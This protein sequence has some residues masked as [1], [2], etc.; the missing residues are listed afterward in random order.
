MSYRRV[1][2]LGDLRSPVYEVPGNPEPSV[3]IALMPERR[4]SFEPPDPHSI[5][6][7]RL[8]FE[9]VDTEPSP[10]KGDSTRTYVYRCDRL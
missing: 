8:R 1:L 4:L 9:Y 7:Y 5:V 3:D 2:V 6:A 10:I